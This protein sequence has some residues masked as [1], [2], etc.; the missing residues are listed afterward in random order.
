MEKLRVLVHSWESSACS[1]QF[2][3]RVFFKC[4]GFRI[5]SN[6]SLR[7]QG[8]SFLTLPTPLSHTHP[9]SRTTG[10]GCL[11][12]KELLLYLT[13]HRFS[14]SGWP[15]W[16]VTPCPHLP[17]TRMLG[18]PPHQIFLCTFWGP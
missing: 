10:I 12:R 6:K 18:R 4:F 15:A 9:S 7:W 17:S 11:P 2:S 3:T 13:V 16:S 8:D 1:T 14:C 5:N